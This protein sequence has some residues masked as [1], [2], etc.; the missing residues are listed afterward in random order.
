MIM[1]LLICLDKSGSDCPLTQHHT[2]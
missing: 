1:R 2:P